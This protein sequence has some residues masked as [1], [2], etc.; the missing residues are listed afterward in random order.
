MKHVMETVD[1]MLSDMGSISNDIDKMMETNNNVNPSDY[2]AMDYDY[3]S[4]YTALD[5]FK[6][7]LQKVIGDV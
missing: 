4:A 5:C 1:R 2:H 7:S 3:Y 6:K